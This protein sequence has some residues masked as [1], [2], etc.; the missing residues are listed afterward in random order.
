MPFFQL[1]FLQKFCK[2][3]NR[4]IV[5]SFL[6]YLTLYFIREKGYKTVLLL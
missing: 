2:L 3:K 6:R 5:L 1:L 4:K